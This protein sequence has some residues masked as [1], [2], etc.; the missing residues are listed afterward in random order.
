M[1]ERERGEGLG[2]GVNKNRLEQ[3]RKNICYGLG[4]PKEC[5]H[6]AYNPHTSF[7]CCAPPRRELLTQI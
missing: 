5:L 4:I 7:N 6:V 1:E 3:Y 2:R